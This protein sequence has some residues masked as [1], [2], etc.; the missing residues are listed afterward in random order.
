L[1]APLALAFPAGADVEERAAAGALMDLQAKYW[2]GVCERETGDHHIYFVS[3]SFWFIIRI[4]QNNAIPQPGTHH[5]IVQG[6]VSL[7]ATGAKL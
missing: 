2:A 1:G 5:Q 6:N 7:C 4:Q 3:C